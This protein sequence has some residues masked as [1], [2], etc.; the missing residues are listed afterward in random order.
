MRNKMVIYAS[1][2][3]L[4]PKSA[5]KHICPRTGYLRAIM[6]A[7]FLLMFTLICCGGILER[8]VDYV[9]I[10]VCM[11]LEGL[12]AAVLA[13]EIIISFLRGITAPLREERFFAKVRSDLTF[14]YCSGRSP[15]DHTS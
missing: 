5:S 10:I 11:S 13:I 9:A 4:H 14:L 2:F 8:L 6:I 12:S 15:Q 7:I 3:C 1:Q